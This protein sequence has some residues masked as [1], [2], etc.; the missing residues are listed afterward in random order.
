MIPSEQRRLS[1][2]PGMDLG[3]VSQNFYYEQGRKLLETVVQVQLHMHGKIVRARGIADI[4][5]ELVKLGL[6]LY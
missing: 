4:F 3:G 1:Y 2:I 6:K 5:Q